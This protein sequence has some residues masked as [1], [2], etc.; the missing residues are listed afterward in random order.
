[1]SQNDHIVQVDDNVTPAKLSFTDTFNVTFPL[2]DRNLAEGRGDR[3]VVRWRDRELTFGQL[4]DNVFRMANAF[5]RLGVEPGERVMLLVKDVPGFY[6]GFLAAIRIGAIPIPV[7]YFLRGHDYT[8]MLSDSAAKVVMASPDVLGEI[9]PAIES[10]EK[11]V[12]VKIVVEG[13][14]DGWLQL[15]DLLSGEETAADPE[16][17]G[18]ETDCFW[19]YSSGSTG[20]PKASVHQHKDM[21]YT[22]Q[23]YGIGT[24]GLKESSVG[25]SPPKAFFAYGLGNS[26]SFPLWTGSTII[27]LEERPT[28]ENTLE[29]MNTM[30][31]T[32]YYGVPTL[33]AAQLQLLENGY[34][35]DLSSIEFCASGG[36]A[37]PPALYERWL[38]FTG[39]EIIDSIG[40]SEGLHFYTSNKPGNVKLGTAGP[41]VPGYEGRIVDAQGNEIPDGEIGELA[42]KGE[43]TAAYYWN[44]PE[45]TAAAM[46]DGWFHTGDTCYRDEDGFYVFCG[47]DSDMLKVGGIWVSPVEVESALIE[48]S[49]VLEAAVTGAPDDEQLI[50]PKAFVVL[51]EPKDASPELEHELREFIR[52][53]LAPFKYPRWIEFMDELPKTSS[54]KIQRFRLRSM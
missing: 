18:P 20:D 4:A 42:I 34:E 31:P 41:I 33:Y 21:I 23:Y 15:D 44:K 26:V 16:P 7:N 54:G 30:K 5:R 13:E 53:R 51:K 39:L 12:A 36:E 29:I 49:A 11:K 37:L 43:S 28:P 14:Q 38:E 22:S 48:H 3:V 32:H 6:Y 19:L 52:T 9:I 24:I 45:K 1:M 17:T 46:R 27:L 35:A 2:L 47:R 10:N 8:Y 40:S 25:F 50:K